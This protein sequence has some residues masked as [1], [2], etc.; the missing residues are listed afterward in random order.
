MDEERQESEGIGLDAVPH[1]TDNA[2]DRL[3]RRIALQIVDLQLGQ[4]LVD[5]LSP[6]RLEPP[7]RQCLEAPDEVLFGLFYRSRNDRLSFGHGDNAGVDKF[8]VRLR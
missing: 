4:Q 3:L 6:E 8:V 5:L 2:V 1:L 7:I